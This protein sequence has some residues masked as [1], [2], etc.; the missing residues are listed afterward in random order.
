MDTKIGDLERP[1]GCHC[2]LFQTIWQL[3]EPTTSNLL[4]L[5]P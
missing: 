2:A 1:S 4:E 5:D 3:W